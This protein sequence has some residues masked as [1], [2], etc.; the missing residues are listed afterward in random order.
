M[1]L[2]PRPTRNRL[3]AAKL[4]E[5][6][7]SRTHLHG[8]AGTGFEAHVN[9]QKSTPAAPTGYF[10]DAGH[11]FGDRGNG[12][13][14]GWDLDATASARD[15]N[16]TLSPDQRYDT[17]NHM[18]YYGARTWEIAVPD[19]QYT[20]HLVGGDPSESGLSLAM[21]VEGTIAINGRTSSTQRWLEGTVTVE[22]TDG[23]LTVSNAPGATNNKINFIDIVGAGGDGHP[24]VSVSAPD[25]TASEAGPDSAT[26][27]VTRQGDTADPLTVRYTFGG[28]ATAGADYATLSGEVV[29]PAGAP[30]ASVKLDPIDDSAEE[31]SESV[32]LTLFPSDLYEVAAPG[33]AT[34]S[35]ADN[36]AIAPAFSAKVNFQ[37][38]GAAVPAGYVADT[39]LV[40]GARGNGST[41]G[42]NAS[43]AEYAR[44]RDS[45][46]SP[47]QRYDTVNQMQRVAGGSVWEIAV[48][49]GTYTVRIVAGDAGAFDSV[50]AIAA[51]GLLVA[52]GR[53]TS[54]ARWFEG[55]RTVTVSDG[56]LTV[57]NAEGSRNNKIAFIDIT[58]GDTPVELPRVTVTAP[59]ASASEAGDSGYFRISRTGPNF[60]RLVVRVSAAGSA[61]AGSDYVA[62]PS[63]VV[64]P[65]GA[66]FVNI[67]LDVI[68]DTLTE[69]TETVRLSVTT[70]AGY[71]VG[72]PAAA[73]VNLAD[74]DAAPGTTINWTTVAGPSIGR[75]EAMGAMV[76]GKL[77]LFGGYVD[78]TFKPTTRADVYDPA[79]DTWTQIAS[80]PFGV[81]HAGTVA[82]GSSIYF[83]GGYPATSSSQSFSTTRVWR[84]DTTTNTYSDLPPLPAARGGGAL[85]AVGRN[86]HFF[87]GSDS[88]RRD[89]ASHWALDL[90]NLAA[91]WV[92]KAA[93]PLARNHVAGTA[94]NGL[95]YAVGGQQNQDAAA[96][97]R[98]EVDVYDPATDRWTPVAPL[99][100][101][102]S[103]ITNATVVLN[104]QIITLGGLGA[105][106]RTLSSV[107][108]YNPATNTWT[109]LTPL[110][111]ARLSGIAD[112][113]PDG[114]LI[115]STGSGS[116]FRTTT[117]I[118][119]VV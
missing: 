25:A 55:T 84:Y 10:V 62:L 7:E 3:P 82:V 98:A 112:V 100:T 67:P 33:A 32:T 81:S 20:V 78:T 13:T 1:S 96:I 72:S 29:I 104:G 4:L 8:G 18:Q 99:P 19:G 24:L 14:Y 66:S 42:W 49:N 80:L 52:G 46:L 102:R 28:T 38:A 64:I 36:D 75:S 21:A 114:R 63:S 30:S 76:G 69:S 93:L 53:P 22:V 106:N 35:I 17:L 34:V 103:H 56:R 54:T 12:L 45:A 119:Q 83:A 58:S 95:I 77:Y 105:G 118:G 73:T 37:P 115:F 89:A 113:L 108:R 51:E 101:G 47:D 31:S 107:S 59:D 57:S 109:D 2:S 40:Y 65:A 110:P 91:A 39:G 60:Q 11:V 16:S 68:D 5:L 74:N 50:Y 87:G 79:T 94:V 71:T 70:G 27:L 86:L 117:W 85:A 111:S 26:F 9:F 43:I 44:D 116:G 15:R 97:H 90:D 61:A 88:S 48:P 92:T 6:L 23:R 41:Y